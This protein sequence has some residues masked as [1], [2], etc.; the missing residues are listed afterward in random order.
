MKDDKLYFV[1]SYV[2]KGGDGKE[3]NHRHYRKGNKMNSPV[4]VY[5]DDKEWK[6]FTN[7]PKAKKSAIDHIKMDFI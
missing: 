3:H 7:L 4:V 2:C 5:I 1:G 6:T